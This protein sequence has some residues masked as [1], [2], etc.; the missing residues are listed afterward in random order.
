MTSVADCSSSTAQKETLFGR[1]VPSV[2]A[3]MS[4]LSEQSPVAFMVPTN[5]LSITSEVPHF[6][7]HSKVL[8]HK[9]VEL[10]GSYNRSRV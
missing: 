8:Y 7:M 1:G 9:I 4:W 2:Q 5:S 3:A 6:A 10:I